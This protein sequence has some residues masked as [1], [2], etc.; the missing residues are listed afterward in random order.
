MYS[1]N[2]VVFCHGQVRNIR[3]ELVPIGKLYM[4]IVRKL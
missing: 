1:N 4:L 3:V 2:Q